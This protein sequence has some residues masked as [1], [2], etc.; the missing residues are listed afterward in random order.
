MESNTNNVRPFCIICILRMFARKFS[1]IDF[2]L[3]ILP[4]K[5]YEL[6]MSKME[7]NGGS[8][9][10]FWR[11]HAWKNTY[12]WV[13]WASLTK[14]ATVA[15]SPK[16]LELELWREMFSAKYGLNGPIK[17]I[18]STGEVPQRI[19]SYLETIVSHALQPQDGR[20]P[21]PVD[22]NLEF[23]LTFHIDFCSFLN[24]VEIIVNKIC[25]SK[26]KWG[27]PNVQDC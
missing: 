1:N 12:I 9:T 8:P 19:S 27:S 18:W 17:W 13:N 7:K 21:C 5:D 11:E 14:K 23:F 16:I 6:V 10:L 15:A 22:R 2:F 25:F 4:L 26:E 24:N 3:K 20:I